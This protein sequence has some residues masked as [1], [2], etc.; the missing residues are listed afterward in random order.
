MNEYAYEWLSRELRLY[1]VAV[2]PNDTVPEL[3]RTLRNTIGK[4]GDLGLTKSS[5]EKLANQDLWEM[6]W[7]LMLKLG[8]IR[9]EHVTGHGEDFWNILADFLATQGRELSYDEHDLVRYEPKR[10]DRRTR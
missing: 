4:Q 7:K 1:G 9:F 2:F 6:L 5:G 10:R 8:E 3:Y